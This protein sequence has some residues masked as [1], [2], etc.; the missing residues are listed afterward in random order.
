[1]LSAAHQKGTR[2]Q[3]STLSS[4]D[5]TDDDQGLHRAIPVSTPLPAYNSNELGRSPPSERLLMAHAANDDLLVLGDAIDEG[6]VSSPFQLD[7]DA[8]G[9]PAEHIAPGTAGRSTFLSA[10]T[11]PSPSSDVNPVPR[12]PSSSKAP[13]THTA[14]HPTSPSRADA[15]HQTYSLEGSPAFSP[16]VRASE[17]LTHAALQPPGPINGRTPTPLR[18][19]PAPAADS[20]AGSDVGSHIDLYHSKE[21][22]IGDVLERQRVTAELV[23]ETQRQLRMLLAKQEALQQVGRLT[24]ACKDT[25]WLTVCLRQSAQCSG[26]QRM[27][28]AVHAVCPAWELLKAACRLQQGAPCTAHHHPATTVH[29]SSPLPHPG[30]TCR[31]CSR[32][33]HVPQPSLL[34]LYAPRHPL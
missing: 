27:G 19:A 21:A 2:P 8:P 24:A 26:F 34:P 1:M 4:Q 3:L 32:H 30:T 7:T 6:D 31:R 17:A 15:L 11:S 18:A 5:L 9:A 10:S 29:T 13:G 25:S 20:E 33:T 12:Q 22:T 14:Q 16:M 28:Q 23:A